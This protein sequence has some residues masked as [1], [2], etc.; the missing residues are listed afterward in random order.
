ML[1]AFTGAGG[2]DLGLEA[3]GYRTVGCIEVDPDARNTIRT[4]RPAWN[5]LEP[6]DVTKLVRTLEPSDVGLGKRE[7]DVLVGGPPCQ[8]F[9]NAAQWAA[10]AKAGMKDQRSD[11]IRSFFGLVKIFLPKVVLLENVEG[12]VLGKTSVLRYIKSSITHIEREFG[13]QYR[14]HWKIIDACDYGV[15]QRRR[16]A[17]VVLLRNHRGGFVWPLPTHLSR[18]VR[19]WDALAGVPNGMATETKG[20][21]APLLASVPEGQNYLFHTDRGAGLPLFGYRTRYWSF[22]L[23]LA[24]DQP[25]WTLPAQPGPSTG[26]FHWE[27][28]PLT[29]DELLRL[30]T[31]PASWEVVG[32]HRSQVR[33]V[34]NATP[35]LLAEVI[36]RAIGEQIFGLKYGKQK[37]FWVRRKRMMQTAEPT[38]R[39]PSQF[40]NMVGKHPPHPGSGLGPNPMTRREK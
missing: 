5:L 24:K 40:M 32:T 7:L 27:N 30:Q 23:K 8:P 34:G 21:W 18:P 22:L 38:Q 39:V 13:T 35:P 26:P 16:R 4:N 36:G 29:V 20:K 14:L 12:F 10:S 15:P 19:A 3:A 2:S 11:C 9:S 37:R 31:F 33:Q 17:L 28:R 25:S 6:A 1:S